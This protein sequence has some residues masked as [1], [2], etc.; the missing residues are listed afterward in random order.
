LKKL[1]FFLF[2]YFV[3]CFSANAVVTG[4]KLIN[5]YENK[6]TKDIAL[7]YINGAGDAMM[8]TNT[9]LEVMK[10]MSIMCIPKKL[11]QDA[12][13]YYQIF[14]IQYFRDPVKSSKD[15]VNLTLL[16]GMI[17]TYPCS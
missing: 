14:K 9:Y 3:L 12:E 16:W 13:G 6:N 10:K 4:E 7:I 2:V 15:P 17:N 8:W 11:A 5:W 1:F